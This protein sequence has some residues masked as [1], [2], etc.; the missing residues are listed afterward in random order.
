MQKLKKLVVL[1]LL[2]T[3]FTFSSMPLTPFAQGDNQAAHAQENT[4]V[5]ELSSADK[6]DIKDLRNG[7]GRIFRKIEREIEGLQERGYIS[8]NVQPVIVIVKKKSSS[9]WYD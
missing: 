4:I 7:G 3:F 9:S 5:L 2:C 1:L 8:E 6:D